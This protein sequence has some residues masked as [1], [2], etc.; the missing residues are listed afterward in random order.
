MSEWIT[1]G[2]VVAAGIA[3]WRFIQADIRARRWQVRLAEASCLLPLCGL[4]SA[5]LIVAVAN[6]ALAWDPRDYVPLAVG[7]S[8]T[9]EHYYENSTYPNAAGDWLKPFEVPG[10]PHGPDQPIPPDSL[11]RVQRE[12]TVEITHTAEIEGNEYWVFSDVPYEWPPLPELFWAGQTVRLEHEALLFRLEDQDVFAFGFSKRDEMGPYW[13]DLPGRRVALLP[14]QWPNPTWMLILFWMEV[15]YPSRFRMRQYVDFPLGYGIGRVQIEE[16][17]AAYAPF[18]LQ[19][20]RPMSARIDGETVLYPL[21]N[22][23]HPLIWDFTGV[24][25]ASW[26]Q[27]KERTP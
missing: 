6:P 22:P 14:L 18:Y 8:W 16:L 21:E 24:A 3:L 4:P 13:L 1:A 7:N 27:V 9:Y 19:L 20:L 26:G 15:E 12:F 10:Y 11:L 5:L 17:A 23:P 2:I 25:A